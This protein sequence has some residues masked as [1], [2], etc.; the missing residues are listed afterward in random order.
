MDIQ[1]CV[2][3]DNVIEGSEDFYID[4]TLDN[5]GFNVT[6]NVTLVNSRTV[7]TITDSNCEYSECIKMCICYSR[8]INWKIN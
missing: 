4:W 7:V 6:F 1:L 5:M 3:G 2:T 8:D